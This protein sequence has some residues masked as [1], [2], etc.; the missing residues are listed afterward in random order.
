MYYSYR[1]IINAKVYDSEGLYYGYVCGLN[2]VSRPELKICIEYNIGDKIPDIDTL[3]K[4][5]REKNL[6]IPEDISLE[7]LLLAARNEGLEIPYIEVEKRVDFTKSFIELSEVSVID[8]IYRK[9]SD[10]EWRVSIIVLNKPCEAV[11]RGYPLPYSNPYIEQIEK[12]KGKLVVSSSEGIIGYVEDIVIAPNDIGL[13]IDTCNY[14]RGHIN[15]SSFLTIFKTR[16]FEDHY[17]MLIDSIGN[18]DKLDISYYGYIVHILRRIKAPV[19]AFTL[20]NN[21]IEFEE[22]VIEKY[23]DIS[24]RDVLKTG[25]IVITK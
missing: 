10:Y 23:R 19:E 25:D 15:W 21:T 18:R 4:N 24:W 13:R 22:E 8:N 16:G 1:E 11:Y 7:D 17:S 9:S 14:R 3:K 12:T 20:L 5:L 6:E 2:L